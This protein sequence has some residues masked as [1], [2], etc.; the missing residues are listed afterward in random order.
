MADT[1]ANIVDDSSN[2]GHHD[3]GSDQRRL[4]QF[5]GGRGRRLIDWIVNELWRFLSFL[6]DIFLI[7][8]E[9]VAL[10]GGII[11]A[12]DH[13]MVLGIIILVMLFYWMER[14][15]RF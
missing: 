6:G 14:T 12:V 13:S 4:H 9:V 3:M 10:V 15:R 1:T 11:I 5:M 2:T 8:L 7:F